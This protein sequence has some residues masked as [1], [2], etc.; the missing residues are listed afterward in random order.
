MVNIL[1]FPPELVLE[2]FERA[3]SKSPISVAQ[4][5]ERSETLSSLALVNSAWTQAAQ[6]L[7]FETIFIRGRTTGFD[8]DIRKKAER[9]KSSEHLSHARTKRL[10]IAGTADLVME[11]TGVERW[12]QVEHLQLNGRLDWAPDWLYRLPRESYTSSFTRA[13][14]SS[15]MKTN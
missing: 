5:H 4:Y 2:L 12:S 14:S 13:S 3:V 6:L 1:S 9:L 10:T 8:D 7:L 15:Q 11:I